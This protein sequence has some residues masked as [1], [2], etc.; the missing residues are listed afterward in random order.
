MLPEQGAERAVCQGS[1]GGALIGVLYSEPMAHPH[2]VFA[3]GTMCLF[4]AGC[5]GS[6]GD[7]DGAA[8]PPTTTTSNEYGQVHA[9]EFHR[10]PVDFAETEW[11]NACA[12]GGGYRMALR[13]QTGLGGEYLAGV[14]RE[15][16][17]G[18]GVCDACILIEAETGKS[19]VA[20]VVTYGET[21]IEDLDVSLSVYD[22]LNPDD[23]YPRPMTWQ[24]AKCPDTGTLQYE[25]QTEANI[26]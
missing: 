8:G 19:I 5:G 6:F 12:P 9:G 14:S 1:L 16:A 26:W 17:D 25:F 11:H 22:F 18:G 21:G 13:E 23:L 24:F 10:G 3:V 2:S 20:R 7:V 4:V 15:R